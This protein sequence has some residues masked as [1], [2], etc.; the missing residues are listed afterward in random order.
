MASYNVSNLSR[1]LA[2]EL[3][4][5][6]KHVR[7]SLAM[8]RNHHG[9]G[10]G[11][12]VGSD[13]LILTNNHVVGRHT[14]AVLLADDGEYQGQLV[15]R[16]PEIDLA[17]LKIAATGLQSMP[18]VS[19]RDVRIGEMA[20]ALGHPWGQRGYLTSGIISA[21]GTA[22]T[23]GKRKLIP[24]LRS[25]VPLAP[26]NSGG[27]LVNAAGEL[28]GINT[29]IVGGDQS[30]SIPAWIAR[31]FIGQAAARQ[32]YPGQRRDRRHYAHAAH[33]GVL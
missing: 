15:A 16:E 28:L 24:I 30:V 4:A 20:F 18:F 2:D 5:L 12:V 3:D 33:P 1:L 27:P 31:E 29:M 21:M 23:G 13:G 8:V 17:L 10:A 25:D 7:P 14:P 11:I 6:V 22:Q 26:G 9:A 19:A 32:S